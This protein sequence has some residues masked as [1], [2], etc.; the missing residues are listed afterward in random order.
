[1]LLDSIFQGPVPAAILGIAGDFALSFGRWQIKGVIENQVE[2]RPFSYFAILSQ[3]RERTIHIIPILAD[4]MHGGTGIDSLHP[5]SICP[6]VEQARVP[7]IVG[8]VAAPECSLEAATQF[9]H[10][11]GPLGVGKELHIYID[12]I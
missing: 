3:E 10:G 6:V 5:R 1:M 12:E 7:A 2:G 11:R 4:V 9:A 8:I